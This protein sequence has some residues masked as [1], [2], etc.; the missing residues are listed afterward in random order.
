MNSKTVNAAK[1]LAE[2]IRAFN[3]AIRCDAAAREITRGLLPSL[4]KV[5]DAA[6]A[7]AESE[8]IKVNRSPSMCWAARREVISQK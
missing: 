2:A 8:E 3:Y 1:Q 7:I 5:N 4:D 6:R